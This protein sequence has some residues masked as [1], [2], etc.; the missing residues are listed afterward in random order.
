MNRR[1]VMTTGTSGT[2]RKIV[3][4]F[5]VQKAKVFVCDIDAKALSPPSPSS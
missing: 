2:G 3:R 1:T 5:A 4:A